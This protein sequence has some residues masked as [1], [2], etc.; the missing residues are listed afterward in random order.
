MYQ[1]DGSRIFVKL[2]GNASNLNNFIDIL[3]DK[4]SGN[5]NEFEV[6]DDFQVISASEIVSIVFVNFGRK[7]VS[8]S[9]RDNSS[10]VVGFFPYDKDTSH[11]VV[12]N[13]LR[14]KGNVK[15]F[16]YHN[17]PPGDMEFVVDTI[18]LRDWIDL[19]GIEYTFIEGIYWDKGGQDRI[20]SFS[21]KIHELRQEYKRLNNPMQSIP[22]FIGNTMYGRLGV[23][24]ADNKNIP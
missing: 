23:S 16:D 21:R 10:T 11:P 22:K 6:S 5:D 20:A 15:Y 12:S 1:N 24:K 2:R 7:N 9:N 19:A 18:T 8:G 3:R 4:Y 13:R 17:Q 14:N